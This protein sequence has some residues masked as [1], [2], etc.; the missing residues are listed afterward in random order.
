MKAQLRSLLIAF[1]LLLLVFGSGSSAMAQNEARGFSK[2]DGYPFIFVS[3]ESPSNVDLVLSDSLFNSIA[4]G[5]QFVVNRTKVDTESSFFKMYRNELLPL[6]R[7]EHLYPVKLFIRGAASPE[8]PYANNRRLGMG[9]TQNLLRILSESL[10]VG[11]LSPNM[12]EGKVIT[13]DY[14]YLVDLMYEANDPDAEAV[15][16]LMDSCMWDEQECKKA[17]QQMRG[18][19]VWRRLS[20]EYFP[21]L[22]SARI[23]L[24]LARR[25][26]T[27]STYSTTP[28]VTTP[29]PASYTS[30]RDTI[31]L[32]DTIYISHTTTIIDDSTVYVGHRYCGG[33]GCA[34]CQ[35]RRL[36]EGTFY[37]GGP[38]F[39]HN[40]A[41]MPTDS[42]KR[43][44]LLAIKTN[45]LFDLVTALNAS[46]EVPIADRFSA[47]AEVVWPWWVD[48]KHN[49]WCL[50][51]GNV[52]LEGRYYFRPWQRHS[53][54]QDWYLQHNGPLQGGFVGLHAD[55]TY[56]DFEWQ[57]N[58]H[59]GEAWSAGVTLGYQRRLSRQCNLEFSFGVGGA[60]HQYRKYDASE[61]EQHLWRGD[62]I[63]NQWYFG[64]TKAK[65]SL[66]WLL[67]SRCG[68]K[69]QKG[70]ER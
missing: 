42:V 66:V 19:V 28:V 26:Q 6:L 56:Y 13:E 48:G 44:P 54:F 22:R 35:G 23:V 11:G 41:F 60:K 16:S 61:D 43:H 47:S 32:R 2:L 12:I 39:G 36:N 55:A 14:G 63:K 9:R 8:G 25:P 65:I 62:R 33:A 68:N 21:R 57:G 31:Y 46:I 67:Y 27:T 58:G 4:T 24:W 53:T 15:K 34:F 52:G 69:C 17:L 38:A 1:T 45:L 49:Q 51:M 3:D 40:L 10:N 20:Q 50:Q 30:H 37:Y 64:P 7:R 18:G 5:V 70:D 59:Q 29:V